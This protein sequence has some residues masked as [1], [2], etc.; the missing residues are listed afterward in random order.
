MELSKE[1]ATAILLGTGHS[2]ELVDT[3]SVQRIEAKLSG[4]KDFAEVTAPE[5][6]ATK[7]AFESMMKHLESGGEVK[8]IGDNSDPTPVTPKKKK[9]EKAE[10]VPTAIADTVESDKDPVETKEEKK[11]RKIKEKKEKDAKIPKPAKQEHAPDKRRLVAESPPKK[12]EKDAWGFM[13]G[14]EEYAINK[15]FSKEAKNM[16]TLKRES[17]TY[18]LLYDHVQ[19]MIEKGYVVDEGGGKYKLA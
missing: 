11:A 9:K 7:E 4:L 6:P 13:E 16:L 5:D 15:A 18:G 19:K 2:S 1:L 17:G 14:S 12:P 10:K 8:V 3:L